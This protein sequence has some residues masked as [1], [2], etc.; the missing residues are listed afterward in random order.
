MIKK[1]FR[2][3]N[4]FAGFFGL[5]IVRSSVSTARHELD[6][7]TFNGS[8]REWAQISMYC[9]VVNEILEVPGDVAEFGVAGGTSLRSFTRL[10]STMDKYKNHEVAKKRVYGFD[11][12]KGLPFFD[13]EIDTGMNNASDMVKGGY[14]GASEF[15]L[16]SEFAAKHNVEL[17]KGPFDQTL[18]PFLKRFKHTTFSMLHIDCDLHQSTFDALNPILERL[19]IGGIILFDE[20][21]HKDFPG[22]TTGFI[23]SLNSIKSINKNFQLEFIRVTSMP[24]KWYAKRVS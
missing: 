2:I 15:K 7:F 11:T 23:E 22:E 6:N 5:K 16:L 8:E 14:D 4:S 17:V 9:H 1:I 24:W 10:I 3:L 18:K 19:N 13:K 21:F 20:I 12:F